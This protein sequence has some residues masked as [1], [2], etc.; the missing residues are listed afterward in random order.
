MM[1][2]SFAA[3]QQ[4]A[5]PR[6]LRPAP[7]LPGPLLLRPLRV[8]QERPRRPQLLPAGPPD[9]GREPQRVPADVLAVAV[10][11]DAPE[12][13]RERVAHQR[14]LVHRGGGGLQRGGREHDA[15]NVQKCQ[16]CFVTKPENVN[17]LRFCG[18]AAPTSACSASSSAA[19]ASTTS[20]R[21]S[22]S[23]PTTGWRTTST[24]D[25]RGRSARHSH[26]YQ[27]SNES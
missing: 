23:T 2:V 25:S 1:K 17:F 5:L 10:D 3:I 19:A 16:N 7:L 24:S 15:G 21:P 13:V 27:S 22:T 26:R 20:S 4:P 8:G 12:H 9:R 6:P 14:G 18:T 11:Q